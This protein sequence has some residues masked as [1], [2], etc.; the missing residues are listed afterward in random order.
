MLHQYIGKW[1]GMPLC[2]GNRLHRTERRIRSDD[3]PLI[4][5]RLCRLSLENRVA[6]IIG[7]PNNEHDGVILKYLFSVVDI[8][9][10][11]IERAAR[12]AA[13]VGAGQELAVIECLQHE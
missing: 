13:D 3:R 5:R 10:G 4:P 9:V 7:K 2:V 1:H 12:A 6:V 11:E 8:S